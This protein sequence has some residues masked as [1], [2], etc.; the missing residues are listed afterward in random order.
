MTNPENLIKT[1]IR[2]RKV[3][4]Y[5]TTEEDLSNVKNNSLL[6]NIGFG[7]TSL[8]ISG[9]ISILLLKDETLNILLYVLIVITVIFGCLTAYFFNKSN[10]T[11]RKIKE[12]GE[13]KSFTKPQE[14]IKPKDYGLEITKAIYWSANKRLDVTEELRQ[15]IRNNTLRTSATNDIKGD[16]E[17]RKAKVLSIDYKINGIAVAKDFKEGDSV[18]LP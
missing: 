6:G 13:V 15:M 9:I 12:S 5:L 1:E 10:K 16:P 3:I 4:Y 17:P 8:A 14:E 11:I 2:G 18:A 7:L